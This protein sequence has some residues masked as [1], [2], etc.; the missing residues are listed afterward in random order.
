MSGIIY[1][2]CRQ[3]NRFNDTL[4]VNKLYLNQKWTFSHKPE[5]HLKAEKQSSLTHISLYL[6]LFYF[7]R[8]V[9]N[10]ANVMIIEPVLLPTVSA[11]P[12]I[13]HG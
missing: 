5:Y 11:Y 1:S 13:I 4:V 7:Q 6:L 3:Q 10:N 12:W 9:P 2:K 8:Y